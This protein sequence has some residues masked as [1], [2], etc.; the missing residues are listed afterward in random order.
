[1]GFFSN[2]IDGIT[3]N[4][5]EDAAKA[6]EAGFRRAEENQQGVID[7]ILPQVETGDQARNQLAAALGLT[8][9]EAQQGFF[10]NFQ[11]DPGFQAQLDAGTRAVDQ[12]ASAGGQLNSGGRAKAL[13][14]F[15]QQQQNQAFN[16]RLNRLAGLTS[17]GQ[18]ATGQ[19][20]GGTNALNQAV[21]GQGN[22]QAGGIIGGANAATGFTNQ[23]LQLGGRLAGGFTNPFG[24]GTGAGAGS[25][26]GFGVK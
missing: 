19:L 3:G 4:A 26:S 23:L 11:N 13:F 12:G 9:L 10:N 6:Q 8:G 18:A 1:M 25:G 22:A 17:F 16:N 2:L 14:R 7:R 24:G 15:G 5:A 20:Q 21:V